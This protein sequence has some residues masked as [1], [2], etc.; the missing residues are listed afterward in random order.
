MKRQI[1]FGKTT[2]PEY[3]DLV[4]RLLQIDQ[5]KRLPINKIFEHPWIVRYR[6][7][8]KYSDEPIDSLMNDFETFVKDKKKADTAQELQRGSDVYE[9]C[10]G[11]LKELEN[12]D[13]LLFKKATPVQ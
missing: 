5:S 9:I 10:E 12:T 11:M 13:K 6:P 7:D 4:D 8:Q 2:S 3:R 1:T